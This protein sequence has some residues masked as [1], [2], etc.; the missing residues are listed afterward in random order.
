MNNKQ[1]TIQ[2]IT[3]IADFEALTARQP[4]L[5]VEFFATW[6]P[7]C[8]AFNP[9]LQQA[10]AALKEQSVMTVQVDV[11]AL[12]SLAEEY[13][14]ESIPTLVYFQDGKAITKTEGERSE[15]EVLDFVKTSMEQ[16]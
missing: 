5:L 11:D 14:V 15:S 16:Q 10:A 12:E 4:K 8:K 2:Q 7:H 1:S 6:C 13:G 3:S 9:V